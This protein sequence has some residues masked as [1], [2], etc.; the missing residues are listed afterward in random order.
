MMKH[1]CVPTDVI[2]NSH[3]KVWA[4][5]D[6]NNVFWNVDSDI[7]MKENEVQINEKVCINEYGY[8]K[9]VKENTEAQQML[10]MIL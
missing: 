7:M 4:N 5:E 1:K 6:D 2:S 9:I 8:S 10:M 3:M